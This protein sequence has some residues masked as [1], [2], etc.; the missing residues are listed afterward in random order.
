MPE[1]SELLSRVQPNVGILCQQEKPYLQKL[2]ITLRS[3]HIM[4]VQKLWKS[5][6]NFVYVHMEEGGKKNPS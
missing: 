6:P 5:D 4:V 2:F 3:A 1:N